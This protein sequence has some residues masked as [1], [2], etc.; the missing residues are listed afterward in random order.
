MHRV[1]ITGAGIVSPLGDT[2]DAFFANLLAARSGIRLVAHEPEV[3]LDPLVA[4]VVDFDPAP[5]FSRPQAKQLDRVSQFSLVAGRQAL[6]NAGLPLGAPERDRFGVYWGTGLG[7]IRSVEDAYI[8]VYRDKT[9]R[10]RPLTVVMGMANA[11]AAHLSMEFSLRGPSMTVSNACASS[12]M[13]LGEA[14]RLIRHGYADAMLAGGAE[15]LLTPGTMRAWQMMGT[16]AAPDREDPAR[17]CKPF[18]AD[19]AGLVLAEGAVALVLESEAHAR[20]R[21]ATI[22]AELAGYGTASDAGHLSKPNADGQARAMREAL[23]DAALNA[24]AIGYI[25]AHGTATEV[26]DIVETQALRQVFGRSPPPVSSTKAL[27][28]HLMGAAG[29]IEFLAGLL[30]LRRGVLPPTAHL[31]KADPLCDLDFIANSPRE[32]GNIDAVLSN[33]FAFGGGDAVLVARRHA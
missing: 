31:D 10:P 20:A 19:R 18:S 7:G 24:D 22:L 32:T 8:S 12:A 2:P 21:G 23:R 25:N 9:G 26:G 6:R 13:A 33:S 16:L 17:S 3:G 28:G 5:H 29:A 15:A 27:H 11:A 1:V 30:A 14:M 4:G